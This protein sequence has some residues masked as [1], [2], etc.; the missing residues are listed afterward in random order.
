[1]MGFSDIVTIIMIVVL[2]IIYVRL[3]DLEKRLTASL[4]LDA[5]LDTLLKH[6]GIQFDLRES[7]PQDAI[8]ALERGNKIEAI[9]HYR[10]ATGVGLKEAKDFIEEVQREPQKGA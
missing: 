1:M 8:Q 2:G 7:L 6:A 10:A 5:K 4:R 3:S 9:K